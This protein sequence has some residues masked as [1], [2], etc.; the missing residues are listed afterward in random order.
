MPRRANGKKY[1]GNTNTKEVHDLDNEQPQCQ[2]NEI[3]SH[4][5]DVYFDNH[6]DAKAQGFDNGHFCLGNS[7]R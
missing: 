7:T 3:I 2:I 4:R 6:E 5:H 1:L